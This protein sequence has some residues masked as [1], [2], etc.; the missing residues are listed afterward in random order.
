M[1]A[2]PAESAAPDAPKPAPIRP[3]WLSKT[4]AGLLLGFA[5]ALAASA[6]L[7]MLLAGLPISERGQL[8]M[9]SVPPVWLGVLSGVYFFASGG[10]A[11]LWLGGASLLAHG[12]LLAVR[13][14]GPGGAA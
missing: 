7:A 4:L 8:A 10:R 11:W 9:W 6:W 14:A 13:L 2:A 3:D 5:L 1:S 12:A